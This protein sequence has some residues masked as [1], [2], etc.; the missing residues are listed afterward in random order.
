MNNINPKVDVVVGNP[1]YQRFSRATNRRVFS[2]PELLAWSIR[3]ADVAEVT[4]QA[5]ED[6]ERELRISALGQ[7]LESTAA[8]PLWRRVCK[9]AMYAEIKARSLDRR[10]VMELALREACRG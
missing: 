5:R 4:G 10:L 8:T 3:Q 6:Y 7:L 2:S 9:H 1:P